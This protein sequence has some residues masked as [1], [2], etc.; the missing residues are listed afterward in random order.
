MA[1]T[2]RKRELSPSL[3]TL[4]PAKRGAHEPQDVLGKCVISI[5]LPFCP[6]L[7]YMCRLTKHCNE[8]NRSYSSV[9][10]H[11]TVCTRKEVSCIYPKLHSGCDSQSITLHR[12]NG[13]FKCIRCGKLIM[14]DQNMKVM[15]FSNDQGLF[16]IGS[17]NMLVNAILILSM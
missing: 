7:I 17:R 11:K 13:S 6:A 4:P 5:L 9:R 16:L 14:K 1:S 3:E 10:A 2:S 12:V 8:C 15:S